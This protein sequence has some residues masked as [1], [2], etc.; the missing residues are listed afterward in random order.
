MTYFS[1]EFTVLESIFSKL[2]HDWPHFR[3]CTVF[4]ETTPWKGRRLYVFGLTIRR[5][6]RSA[7]SDLV[8]LIHVQC[9]GQVIIRL[10]SA[11][12][13]TWA[14]TKQ[15]QHTQCRYNVGPATQKQANVNPT[16]LQHIVFDGKYW[17]LYRNN[18]GS[19]PESRGSLHNKNKA[20]IHRD[21]TYS[22]FEPMFFCCWASVA[23]VCA[24]VKRY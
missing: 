1:T 2:A 8:Y 3:I 23:D 18:I 4:S 20:L 5:R 16:L 14:A 11:Q 17:P 13:M 9:C 15:T 12:V 22:M 7:P 21:R 10:F 24:T 6:W 19:M